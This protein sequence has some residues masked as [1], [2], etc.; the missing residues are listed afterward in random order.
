MLRGPSRMIITRL[1]KKV[2][3]LTISPRLS[4]RDIKFGTQIKD[5]L[6]IFYV[7]SLPVDKLWLLVKYIVAISEYFNCCVH[8]INEDP[9]LFELYPLGH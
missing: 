2:S 5:I 1:H 8:L 3:S 4:Y 9:L 7:V 6:C